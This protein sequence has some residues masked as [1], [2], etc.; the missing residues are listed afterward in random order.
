[1]NRVCEATA[2]S[3]LEAASAVSLPGA[4]AESEIA[5]DSSCPS[6]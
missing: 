1:L 5:N 4:A 3:R 6:V 2:A